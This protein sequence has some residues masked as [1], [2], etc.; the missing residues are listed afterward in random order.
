[1]KNVPSLFVVFAVS[2][3]V[4]SCAGAI[5]KDRPPNIVLMMADD[6]GYGDFGATGNHLIKTPHLDRL[7]EQSFLMTRFYVNAVCSPTRASLMTGR[8][9]YRT[10]V[11]DTFKARSTMRTEEI[12]LAEILKSKGY[13]TGLFGK[14]HLGDTHPYRPMD[15]GFDK[16]IYHLGGGLGQPA[17]PLENDNRYTNPVLFDNGKKFQAKGFCCDVYYGEAIDWLTKQKRA[18][19]PFFAYIATNTPH[20]PLHDLPQAWYDHYKDMDLGKENFKQDQGH[21]I[22]GQVKQDRTARIY[23]MVSNIDENVGKLLA[24]LEDLDIAEDT[25]VIYMS[26]N[27]PAG[28]RYVG[29]F[30]GR[31]S[32]STEGGLRSPIWFR[33]PG[34]FKAGGKSG[35][36]SAHFDIM[37]TL[38]D[39]V[40][41]DMPHDRAID[42][43]SILPTLLGK[44]QQWN[45][46][47][48]VLQSHRGTRPNRLI[49]AAVITQQWKLETNLSGRMELFNMV[50]DPYAQKNVLEE[51]TAVRQRLVGQYDAWF[52]SLDSEYPDMWSTLP[53]KIGA[54]AEPEVFLTRQDM[55]M[56]EK[57]PW[58][59]HDSN[60]HW[61]L[62]VTRSR[63]YHVRFALLK[64]AREVEA[65]LLINGEIVR[66]GFF[67]GQTLMSFGRLS[68]DQGD[69]QLKINVKA[70]GKPAGP[71]HVFIE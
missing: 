43:R 41:A 56:G 32:M 15:Q 2:I 55:V 37:P 44:P 45:D 48:M 9:S 39:L 22:A 34:R 53:L 40:G 13:A 8:S 1:M 30:R 54:P 58:H 59:I 25:L 12:T 42:G 35:L 70:D 38:V 18:D 47:A 61:V 11:T 51:E 69:A 19:K 63:T 64:P 20:D 27:G 14:W 5:A 66:T 62:D 49:N 6:Q 65:E 24:A 71:W 36:V 3:C 29:G 28:N 16:A 21:P 46:R 17:D 57:T 7:A 4:V 31:K 23:A 68:L 33:Y 67:E 52:K 60:G 10:G 50:E 26:D